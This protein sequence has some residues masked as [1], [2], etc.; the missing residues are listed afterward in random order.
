MPV[1][2]ARGWLATLLRQA[3]KESMWARLLS[4]YE[5]AKTFNDWVGLIFAV[6][7]LFGIA[8]IIFQVVLGVSLSL[9]HGTFF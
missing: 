7:V 6:I 1:R 9:W 2:K 4:E 5:N 8:L 3:P